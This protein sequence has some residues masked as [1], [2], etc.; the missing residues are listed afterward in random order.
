ML[1]YPPLTVVTS[2]AREIGRVAA[3]RILQRLAQ[4]DAARLGMPTSEGMPQ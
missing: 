1:A 2:S 3:E 4:P